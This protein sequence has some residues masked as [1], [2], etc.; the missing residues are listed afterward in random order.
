MRKNGSSLFVKDVNVKDIS[1]RH[2]GHD[3]YST[4]GQQNSIVALKT[5]TKILQNIFKSKK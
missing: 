3:K 4:K 1:A 5:I 2:D